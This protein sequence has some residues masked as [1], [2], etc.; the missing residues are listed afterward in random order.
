MMDLTLTVV[1]A[2]GAGL[3]VG[4]LGRGWV[5]RAQE[6]TQQQRITALERRVETLSGLTT[7]D[8]VSR[9]R[10]SACAEVDALKQR[11]ED[12]TRKHERTL[13]AVRTQTAHEHEMRIAALQQE[14]AAQL[15]GLRQRFSADFEQLQNDI[16][17]LSGIIFTLTRWHDE[18]QN[19]LESNRVLRRQNAEF[20]SINKSVVMLALNAAI[21][22]ARAGE[23]GRGFGVVADGVRQLALASTGLAQEYQSNLDK[24]DLVTTTTFQDMQASGNMVR[25][26]IHGLRSAADRIRSAMEAA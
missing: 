3:I 2:L 6:R 20:A 11:L 19:I 12:E 5:A 17:A 1:L 24:S 8:E 16:D 15:S 7:I 10:D 13:E 23:Q 18:M 4:V 9:D 21:E 25:T 14:H 22:A 26:A